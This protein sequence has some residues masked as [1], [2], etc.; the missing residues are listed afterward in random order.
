MAEYIAGMNYELLS[1]AV[2]K[3]APVCEHCDEPKTH[4]CL[5]KC[6]V[7]H[8]VFC[9]LCEVKCHLSHR[10]NKLEL[11]FF[12]RKKIQDPDE[13]IVKSLNDVLG[14]IHQAKNT[15]TDLISRYL[16]LS[17][18]YDK[19]IRE[20]Q[21]LLAT[22][23]RDAWYDRLYTT[24]EA[25]LFGENPLKQARE[26]FRKGLAKVNIHRSKNTSLDTTINLMKSS[27]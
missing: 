16:E 15:V 13:Y 21:R 11:L 5:E 7:D 17:E 10:T 1:E 8:S 3:L 20:I 23:D 19:N 12:N 9:Q 24:V 14:F 6:C 27:E 18:C 2:L 22:C 26:E 25:Y 4:I